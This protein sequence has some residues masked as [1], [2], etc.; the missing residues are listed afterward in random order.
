MPSGLLHHLQR[1]GQPLKKIS[2]LIPGPSWIVKRWILNITPVFAKLFS[3][4]LLR[5][6]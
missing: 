5:S 3:S 4:V 6:G 1:N 2:V